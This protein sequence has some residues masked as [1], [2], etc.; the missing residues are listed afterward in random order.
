MPNRRDVLL[1]GIALTGLPLV[2]HAAWDPSDAP[3]PRHGPYRVLFDDRFAESRRFGAEIARLGGAARAFSG[4]VTDVWYEDLD[5]RWRREPVAVAGM[6]R[7]GPL[8]CLE[9]LAWGVGMRVA[10]RAEHWRASDGSMAHVI[11]APEGTLQLAADLDIA[12]IDWARN[13]ARI[14]MCCPQDSWSPAMRQFG[15]AAPIADDGD[16]PLISWIIAP[17]APRPDA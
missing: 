16:D 7:H 2:A 13:A 9:R 4:D 12:N 11:V 1:G 8:F 17:R 15:S 10:Y 14:V 6:T 5:V 3:R